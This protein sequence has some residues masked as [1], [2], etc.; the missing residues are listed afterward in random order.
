MIIAVDNKNIRKSLDYTN[1]IKYLKDY[2]KSKGILVVAGGTS[3]VEET[4][5]EILKVLEG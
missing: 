4:T 5:E 2:Y 1:D 3:S